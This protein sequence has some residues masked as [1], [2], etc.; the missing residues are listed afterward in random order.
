MTCDN[1]FTSLPLATELLKQHRVTIT[2]TIRKNKRE[3][4][5]N[6]CHTS[7]KIIQSS[8]FGFTYDMN[9]VSHVP[10]KSK[11][12]LLLFTMHHDNT[13]DLNLNKPEIITF[14][15][16]IKESVDKVDELKGNYSV[17]RIKRRWPL[18]I[19]YSILNIMGINSQLIYQVNNNCKVNRYEFLQKLGKQLTMGY[20]Q[21]RRNITTL[22]I[23]VKQKMLQFWTKNT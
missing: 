15:N 5:L 8:M 4:P 16:V 20:L 18:T 19:F 12:V 13:I 10:K 2:W 23:E 22:P 17:G 14:Y 21:Q 7:G 1:W 3:T 11:V 6:F 9:L